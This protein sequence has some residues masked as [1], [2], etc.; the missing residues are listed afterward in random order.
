MHH[1]L[2]GV[3]RVVVSVGLVLLVT[4]CGEDPRFS[5]KTQYLGGVYGDAPAGPPRDTVSYWDG[6][7][8][9]E[10]PP[11]RSVSENSAHIFTKAACW[12]VFRNFR[13][14]AKD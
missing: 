2:L 3:L 7:T 1:S 4:G 6:D 8:L 9:A 10:A 12:S 5:G 13:P 14:A 11:L